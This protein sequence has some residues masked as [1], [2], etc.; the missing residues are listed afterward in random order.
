M[1]VNCFL[2]NTECVSLIK[3]NVVMCICGLCHKVYIFCV[4]VWSEVQMLYNLPL[5]L[6]VNIIIIFDTVLTL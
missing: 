1:N 5:N 4:R 2:S 6:C 3:C